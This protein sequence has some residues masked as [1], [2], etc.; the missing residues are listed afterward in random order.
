MFYEIGSQT[1]PSAETWKVGLPLG[2]IQAQVTN[3]DFRVAL[4]RLISDGYMVQVT[5]G[6]NSSGVFIT[7]NGMDH[8]RQFL[9]DTKPVF[10]ASPEELVRQKDEDDLQ[11]MIPVLESK[12]VSASDVARAILILIKRK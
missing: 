3:P 4:D 8:F 1:P 5:R 10:Q 6:D 9:G 2:K 11:N 12:D 7:P